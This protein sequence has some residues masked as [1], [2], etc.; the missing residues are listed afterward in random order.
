MGVTAAFLPV[1]A[2]VLVCG[3]LVAG[4]A[5]PL[6]S[7]RLARWAAERQAVAR[8]RLAAELVEL[9]Q[10]A[11]ELVVYGR[12]AT[13]S[14]ACAQPTACSYAS[15]D[16]MRSLPASATASSSAPPAPPWP[17]SSGCPSRHTR[18]GGSTGC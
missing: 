10:A 9:L 13:G 11:P 12:S 3:L 17:A 2:L 18:T 1:A 8:G 5:V 6:V 7:G 16:G 14:H 4:I 15:A